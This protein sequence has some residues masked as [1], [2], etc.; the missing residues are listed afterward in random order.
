M[1][2]K[3]LYSSRCICSINSVTLSHLVFSTAV[4]VQQVFFAHRKPA[5]QTKRGKKKIVTY[6]L[7]DF[8]YAYNIAVVVVVGAH[9]T[10]VFALVVLYIFFSILYYCFF[11]FSSYLIMFLNIFDL[12]YFLCLLYLTFIY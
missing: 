11:S 8:T 2:E 12:A 10:F 7:H 6:I 5:Q 1:T 3:Q 9:F 4:Y